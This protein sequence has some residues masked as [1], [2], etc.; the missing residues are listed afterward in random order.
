MICVHM[1]KTLQT[2]ILPLISNRSPN[3][4]FVM[5]AR[6]TGPWLLRCLIYAPLVC[7]VLYWLAPRKPYL[8]PALNISVYLLVCSEADSDELCIAIYSVTID[9]EFVFAVILGIDLVYARS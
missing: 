8:F 5:K 6:I 2:L 7:L 9:S 1:L 3:T 4:L